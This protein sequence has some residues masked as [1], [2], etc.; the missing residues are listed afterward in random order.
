MSG[1]KGE[2]RSASPRASGP[3][4]PYT[5][6]DLGIRPNKD[7][8]WIEPHPPIKMHPLIAAARYNR[9]QCHLCRLP[10][11][12]LLQIMRLSDPV[13]LECLRRCSRIFLRLFSTA[14][15]SSAD[16]SRLWLWR[17]P[18][19]ISKLTLEPGQQRQFISLMERDWYCQ[20]CL[21][22]RRRPDW[23]ER[24]R[25]MTKTYLHC[26]G[27]QIDHPAGLFSAEQR[28]KPPSSRTCI[29]HEGRL[30]LC[31]HE[32]ISWSEVLDKA[33][34]LSKKRVGVDQRR[35]KVC[36]R[37]NHVLRGCEQRRGLV[38]T[39][40][41][42]PMP[43]T[44]DCCPP[45]PTAIA[46]YPRGENS[47]YFEILLVW[48]AHVSTLTTDEGCLRPEELSRAI[49]MLREHGAQY[50]CPQLEPGQV[51]GSKLFDPNRCDCLDY[52]GR[53][54]TAWDRPSKNLQPLP[55]SACR[56]DSAQR[57]GRHQDGQATNSIVHKEHRDATFK[58]F[59]EKCCVDMTWLA[60]K[61]RSAN[62]LKA[63][64][65]SCPKRANCVEVVHSSC[66]SFHL[67]DKGEKLPKMSRSWYLSLDPDSYRLTE[68]HE[69]FRLWWCMSEGCRNYYQYNRSR[70]L[71]LLSDY[72]HA[73][74]Y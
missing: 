41:P 6:K 27:C 26:S 21:S 5:I 54:L 23:Q 59:R 38:G 1:Q 43:S 50:I 11:S 72:R 35:M 7:G 48:S 31:E 45:H 36:S 12:I 51:A 10:D 57:F 66:I 58:S 20:G 18:W 30:R 73:C 8:Y 16:F 65:I 60:R 68:D 53:K 49:S 71:P 61:H 29:G 25:I 40:L 70:L 2:K 3:P 63:E 24:L 37:S 47:K 9:T 13:S 4:P 46:R 17:F 14:C 69:G 39:L 52:D 22:A 44:H 64:V 34:V 55:G 62:G 67:E 42:T 74:S 28:S 56:H 33:K 15:A 19:P 32:T